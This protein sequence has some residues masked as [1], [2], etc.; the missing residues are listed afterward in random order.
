M[1]YFWLLALLFLVGCGGT[2]TFTPHPQS[3][4]VSIPV[5]TDCIPTHP[6][7]SVTVYRLSGSCPAALDN[8][9][10]WSIIGSFVPGATLL[11][12]ANG[13]PYATYDIFKDSNV[14]SGGTYSYD[15]EAVTTAGHYSGPSICKTFTT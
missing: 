14:S 15:V 3:T 5:T 13:Q 12:D 9:T 10:G 8:S 1:R 4:S 11:K 6:C 7:A 2:V